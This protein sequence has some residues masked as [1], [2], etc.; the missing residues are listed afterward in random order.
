VTR[1][2]SGGRPWPSERRASPSSAAASRYHLPDSPAQQ[3]RDA[4]LAAGTIG[5]TQQAT[6]WLYDHD[7]GTL[8]A[9]EAA[10]AGR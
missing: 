7:A 4:E 3:Q 6:A 2:V 9:P 5:W 1:P 8:A 10:T